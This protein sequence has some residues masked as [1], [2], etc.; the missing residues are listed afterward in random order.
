MKRQLFITKEITDRIPKLYA[1]DGK[2]EQ[3]IVYAKWF[4][5]WAHW[6]WFATEMDQET[7]EFFG[8]VVG[9]EFELGSFSA[10]EL[11]SI[12]GPMGSALYIE[13]DQHFTPKTVAEVRAE[14]E[15][16]LGRS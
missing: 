12:V 8:L 15:K 7:G 2:G 1:Q 4:C 10:D 5:P 11:K 14:M 3:A 9:H 13:R 6:Y 16:R